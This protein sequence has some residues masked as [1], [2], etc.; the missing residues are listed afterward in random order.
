MSKGITY[1]VGVGCGDPELMTL[2]ALR[3]I[4]ENEIIA[5]VGEDYKNSLAYHIALQNI[6]QLA[7]KN[8]LSLPMPMTAQKDM[9]QKN[10]KNIK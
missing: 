8:I 1:C 7:Q 4:G 2:K 9:I 5:V 6:P 10:I 3:I